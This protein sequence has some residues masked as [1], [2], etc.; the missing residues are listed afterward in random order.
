MKPTI[1]WSQRTQRR[2]SCGLPWDCAHPIDFLF[3]AGRGWELNNRW[4]K[5]WHWRG[6]MVDMARIITSRKTHSHIWIQ[7]PEL[8]SSC[9][10]APLAPQ[11][12]TLVPHSSYKQ[13]PWHIWGA[14]WMATGSLQPHCDPV[15]FSRW[16]EKHQP[17]S[18]NT[19]GI[20]L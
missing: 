7:R 20:R 5:W 16:S 17:W 10:Q 14:Q 15:V 18:D 2:Q 6:S 9:F 19:L 4:P 11:Y 8:S 1:K 3:N 13:S 12:E